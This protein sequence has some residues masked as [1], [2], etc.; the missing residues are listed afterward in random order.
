MKI[1]SEV[2]KLSA[3]YLEDHKISRA[4][5]DAE[6]LLAFVLNIKRIDL[7]MQFDRPLDEKELDA[8]R[9]LLKRKAQGEPVEYI[10]G[11]VDFYHCVLHVTPDVL[12]PRQETEILLDK[13]CKTPDLGKVIWD[14]CCGPGTLGIALKKARP[15]LDV[16]LS[17]IS[18]KALA[19]AQKNAVLNQVEVNFLEG[20]LL[21]PFKG[22]K[23]DV[24]ICNPPYVSEAEYE[25]LENEVKKEPRL[26]LVAEN[27][28]YAFYER[29]SKELPSYLNKGGKAFFEI[30]FAQGERIKSLFNSEI[31]KKKWV[32][33]DF[34]GHDRFFFLEME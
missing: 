8:Y 19:L 6:D 21:F 33:K 32:E 29:L 30:G 14:V 9:P 16:T 17:D 23:A 11:K 7:Y 31:Y 18:P 1:L 4:R 15:E 22:Q 24:I 26:A 10:L 34:A 20:D 2:L 13:I 28:G 5:R 25:E 12:I 3:K 27:E